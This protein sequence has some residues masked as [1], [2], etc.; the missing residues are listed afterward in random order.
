MI[1]MKT[2]I[3]VPEP[4]N[5]RLRHYIASRGGKQGMLAATIVEALTFFLDAKEKRK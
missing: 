1:D 2:T 3:N 5:L 4:L